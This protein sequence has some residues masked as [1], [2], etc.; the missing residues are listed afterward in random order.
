MNMS[1][2][3]YAPVILR[4]NG[5]SGG[6]KQTAGSLNAVRGPYDALPSNLTA[7][8]SSYALLASTVA[9]LLRMIPLVGFRASDVARPW[10]R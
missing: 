6:S 9:S 10:P 2:Q 4:K 8:G 1:G 3:D 5:P 7:H